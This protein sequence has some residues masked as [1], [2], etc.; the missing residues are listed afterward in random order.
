MSFCGQGVICFLHPLL[1]L[2]L[3]SGTDRHS[4]SQPCNSRRL[5]SNIS[6]DKRRRC[7]QQIG[8]LALYLLKG[9]HPLFIRE[10]GM[11]MSDLQS[12]TCRRK[13]PSLLCPGHVV[14]TFRRSVRAIWACRSPSFA[15]RAFHPNASQC[16]R[17]VIFSVAYG[18]ILFRHDNDNFPA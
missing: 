12:A 8:S 10:R 16:N 14:H 9:V 18:G 15:Q 17:R 7:V 2:Q 11:Q 4:L 13:L 5:H 1:G 3:M 6:R